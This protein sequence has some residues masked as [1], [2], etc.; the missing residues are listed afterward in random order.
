MGEIAIA[1]GKGEDV[2]DWGEGIGKILKVSF[3]E[4]WRSNSAVCRYR[5]VFSK[6]QIDGG[7]S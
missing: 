1:V 6:H 7:K 5:L 2:G 4:N 3:L